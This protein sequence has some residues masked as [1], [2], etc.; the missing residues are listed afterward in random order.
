MEI[1]PDDGDTRVELTEGIEVVTDTNLLLLSLM[2]AIPSLTPIPLLTSQLT[3][4]CYQDVHAVM[5]IEVGRPLLIQTDRATRMALQRNVLTGFSE[6]LQV[7]AAAVINTIIKQID[8]L[9]DVSEVLAEPGVFDAL[10]TR[11][12]LLDSVCR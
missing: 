1:D 7:L 10:V 9:L 8:H 11:T 5:V 12:S 6:R 4:P 2:T 3:D